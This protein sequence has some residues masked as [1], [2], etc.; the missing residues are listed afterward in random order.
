MVPAVR[1]TTTGRMTP[2][3]VEGCVYQSE[4]PV[5]PAVEA[6]LAAVKAPETPVLNLLGYIRENFLSTRAMTG[7]AEAADPPRSPR[8]PAMKAAITRFRITLSM[9]IGLRNHRESAV[10]RQGG[11]ALFRTAASKKTFIAGR[12]I[13]M[14]TNRG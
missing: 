1:L 5:E 9:W 8:P 11:V 4:A 14:N 12:E 6:A 3:L 10:T 2:G 13:W 7:A